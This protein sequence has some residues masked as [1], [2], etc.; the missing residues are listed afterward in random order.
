M[1][2]ALSA[3]AARYP[4]AFLASS[5]LWSLLI[6]LLS[7]SQAADLQRTISH[8]E[9]LLWGPKL[10]PFKFESSTHF[11]SELPSTYP[12]IP[13][14][15]TVHRKVGDDYAGTPECRPMFSSSTSGAPEICVRECTSLNVPFMLKLF[16]VAG[17]G[18]SIQGFTV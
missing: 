17:F 2:S 14:S 3:P 13:A 15:A 18:F 11:P 6:R 10:L 16:V 9:W 12:S 7:L 4:L 1:P 5:H 8:T